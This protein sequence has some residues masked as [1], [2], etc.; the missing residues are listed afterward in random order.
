[1]T[2]SG[3]P[4][5]QMNLRDVAEGDRCFICGGPPHD[6]VDGEGHEFWSNAD[7]QTQA[8]TADRR[9]RVTYPG[10]QATPEAAYVAQHRPY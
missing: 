10:G 7:A 5:T 8:Q 9:T 4:V 2:V 6:K 3:H 1:M